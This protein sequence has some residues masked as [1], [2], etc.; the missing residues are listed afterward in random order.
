MIENGG[1]M[2][3]KTIL[4]SLV[5]LLLLFVTA[6][7]STQSLSS[8]NQ[9]EKY[10]NVSGS[11]AVKV[12]P[13]IAY[14]NLGVRNQNASVTDAIEQN[15]MQAQAVKDV[16]VDAGIAEEDIQTSSFS[17]YPQYNYDYDGNIT[18][19][20]FIVE[21]SVYITVRDL[22]N[23]GLLLGS[24][25]E[26]GVNSIYG[27][28]FDVQ[29]KTEALAQSRELAIS[30]ASAQAEE[31][32]ETAGLKLGEILTIDMYSNDVP[33]VVDLYGMGGGAYPTSAS[34]VPISAGNYVITSTA[35]IKFAVE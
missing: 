10:I 4:A 2:K 9:A 30:N 3:K 12:V 25:T 21:N 14:I 13:D 22:D 17:V 20:T 23:L 34:K 5:V 31:I 19:T 7:S 28:T 1:R 6:C 16:L 18:G 11:G 29:D 33:Y 32:A 35:T 26:S 15:S 8:G 24:V 27:I